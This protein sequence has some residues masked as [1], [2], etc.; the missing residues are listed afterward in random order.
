MLE[1]GIKAPKVLKD[2]LCHRCS[3]VNHDEP[4]IRKLRTVGYIHSGKPMFMMKNV[5][6]MYSK[7][8][9]FFKGLSM[10]SSYRILR[11][12]IAVASAV[13]EVLHT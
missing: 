2:M 9:R 5:Y 10:Q 4:C 8:F 13:L 7:V 12:D 1:K 11:R 3:L 6:Y